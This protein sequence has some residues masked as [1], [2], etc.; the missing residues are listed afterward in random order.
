MHFKSLCN[1]TPVIYNFWLKDFSEWKKRTS[2]NLSEGRKYAQKYN[3][4][5]I[6]YFSSSYLSTDF[7]SNN[8]ISPLSE[9][10]MKQRL[11]YIQSQNVDGIIIWD[12]SIGILA[13]GEKPIF[14]INKDFGKA[15]FDFLHAQ[16]S[17]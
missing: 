9:Q 5:L 2:Y 7:P 3:L 12:T 4:K 6:P 1:K 8:V 17:D 11:E 10:E 13:N 14:D 15:L 16:N